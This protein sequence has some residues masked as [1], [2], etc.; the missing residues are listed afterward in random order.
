MMERPKVH[1]KFAAISLAFALAAAVLVN[2]GDPDILKDFLA[3]LG[4]PVTAE[5]FKY[6]GLEPLLNANLTGATSAIVTKA[7]MKEFPALEGQGTSVAVILYPPSGMNPP[8]VHPRGAELLIVLQGILEV[9][10]VDTTNRLYKQTLQTLDLFIFPKGLVHYQIN[11]QNNTAAA[12]LGIFGSANAGTVSLPTT[13]FQSGISPDILAKAFKTDEETIAKG[14]LEANLTGKKTALVA[15][16]TMKEFPALEGQGVSVSLLV[17]PPSGMNLPHIHPRSAELLMLLQGSLEVGFVDTT[18]TLYTETLKPLDLFVFP[19]GLVHFQVNKESNV[20]VAV[21]MFG[22]ASA[23]TVS[24]PTSI[25]E[26]GIRVDILAKAFKTDEETIS[27]LIQ[28][29]FG[30]K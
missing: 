1:Q 19:K 2:A 21:G 9:G 8:H 22:S 7:S 5:Y 13:L 15:K 16:S 6:T 14:I 28:S 18:N 11:T 20:T 24:L 3:P 4:G 12:A 23:G 30:N 29:N 25:F 10:F 26:S 17:Y 27:K